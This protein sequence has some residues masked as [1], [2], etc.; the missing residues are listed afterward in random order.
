MKS[1][2]PS[3]AKASIA[4]MLA[5][6]SGSLLASGGHLPLEYFLKEERP[7]L[8]VKAE[9][10]D[11][12]ITGE[13]FPRLLEI[14]AKA[15]QILSGSLDEPELKMRFTARPTA[16]E[17]K[18]HH[19]GKITKFFMLAESGHEYEIKN[20]MTCIFFLSFRNSDGYWQICRASPDDSEAMII[21]ALAQKRIEDLKKETPEGPQTI[22]AKVIGVS[23]SDKE[24][25]VEAETAG[26]S[27]KPPQRCILTFAPP[28]DSNAAADVKSNPCET[29]AWLWLFGKDAAKTAM[30]PGSQWLF[31]CGKPSENGANGFKASLLKAIPADSQGEQQAPMPQ[32]AQPGQS[33]TRQ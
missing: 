8:I 17:I 6:I 26:E 14:K 29:K 13:K 3:F 25:T 15:L 33:R 24:L 21:E 2:W 9:A 32:Q 19:S 10:I 30:S 1:N 16:V 11:V 7:K 23:A 5:F 4:L 20:G 18:D 28:P 31:T 27:G 12:S 22:K